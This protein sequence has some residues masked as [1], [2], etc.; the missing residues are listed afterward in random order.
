MF[1][2]DQGS[3]FP[4]DMYFTNR[5]IITARMLE[6]VFGRGEMAE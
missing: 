3:Y 6:D 2:S 1:L 5:T 4:A